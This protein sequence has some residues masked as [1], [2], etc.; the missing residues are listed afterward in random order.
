MHEHRLKLARELGATHTINHT[1]RTDVVAAIKTITGPG[2][3]YSLETS[4]LP[5][6]LRE[7]VEAL[8]PA[9]TCVLLGS[10][11]AATEV[12]VEMPFIQPGRTL[13]GVVQ[14]DSQ[15]QTFIPRLTDYMA[16]GQFPIERA[17]TFYDLAD[18]N[19]AAEKLASGRT[20]KPVLRMPH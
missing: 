14:G 18:I 19:R 1:G 8:M 13:R 3:R 12:S 2:V 7:A 9:G 6:V 4:A 20:I 5:E 15:P 11:R 17:I 10:A 16:A